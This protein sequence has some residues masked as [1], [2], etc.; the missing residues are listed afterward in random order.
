[1]KRTQCSGTGTGWC[2]PHEYS[3]EITSSFSFLIVT[4]VNRISTNHT[5]NDNRG[6]WQSHATT[7]GC[8]P[9]NTK[10]KI[11]A[12]HNGVYVRNDKH[13]CY[14]RFSLARASMFGFR[15]TESNSIKAII[16]NKSHE[17]DELATTPS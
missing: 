2:A 8:D 5:R 13:E 16:G 9:M 6:T 15:H 1:M 17:N 10:P 4:I 14:R 3:A 7:Y 11:I 12:S